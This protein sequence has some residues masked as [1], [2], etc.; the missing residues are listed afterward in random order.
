V[1]DRPQLP[2]VGHDHFVAHLL[3]LFADPDRVRA[4]FHRDPHRRQIGKPLLN[5]RGTGTK[6][7]P[8]NHFSIFV[9]R[10]VMAPDIPSSEQLEV[11]GAMVDGPMDG[12]PIYKLLWYWRTQRETQWQWQ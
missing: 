11:G 2:H 3:K 7:S 10:A 5:P 8:V 1:R 6:P 9:E 4:R 12:A